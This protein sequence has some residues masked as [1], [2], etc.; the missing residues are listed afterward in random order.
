MSGKATLFGFKFLSSYPKFFPL[1][2]LVFLFLGQSIDLSA[3]VIIKERV[4]IYPNPLPPITPD[5]VISGDPNNP[6]YLRY[7]GNVVLR[8]TWPYSQV[9]NWHD[10]RLGEETLG[11]IAR[12]LIQG[13]SVMIGPF[14]QWQKLQFWVTDSLRLP[15]ME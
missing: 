3:Q 15:N 11:E 9:T 13:D 2:F 8:L 6:V 7:G 14:P 5:G 4:S 1:I 12:N 10:T